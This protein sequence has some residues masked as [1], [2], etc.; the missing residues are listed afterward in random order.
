MLNVWVLVLFGLL[1][2]CALL[3]FFYRQGLRFGGKAAR[4]EFFRERDALHQRFFELASASGKPKGLRWKE[5]QWEDWVEF[6]RHRKTGE[7]AALVSLTIHFE[8][9]EGGDME[10]LPAVGLPRNATA[11]FYF[12][13]GNWQTDGRAV[14]NHNPNEAAAHFIAEYERVTNGGGNQGAGG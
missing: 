14:F 4:E 6:V 9:I 3:V 13:H 7:L 12:R 1:V 11:V 10:G 2:V 5:C 8:A